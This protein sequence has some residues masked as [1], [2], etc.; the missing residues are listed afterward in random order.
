MSYIVEHIFEDVDDYGQPCGRSAV[1]EHSNYELA[2][3]DVA[4]S[5][6][7]YGARILQPDSVVSERYIFHIYP[8][9]DYVCADD[10]CF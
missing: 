10:I 1:V 2:L 4:N 8:D 7:T 5:T 3:Q 6:A 9:D